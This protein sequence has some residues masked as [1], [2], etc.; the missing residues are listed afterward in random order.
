METTLSGKYQVVIPKTIRRKHNFLPGQKM[1]IT[2]TRDG[3]IVI[4]PDSK[5]PLSHEAVID[6][7][8]GILAGADSPWKRA[9]KDPAVWLREQRDADR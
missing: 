3:H 7:Y 6:K 8:A 5:V 9:G 4:T 1:T 2:E